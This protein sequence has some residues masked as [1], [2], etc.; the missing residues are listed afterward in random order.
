MAFISE[1]LAV[2]LIQVPLSAILVLNEIFKPFYQVDP[3]Q[4]NAQQPLYNTIVWVQD[5][6]HVGY[7]FCVIMRVKCINV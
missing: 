7:P 1:H 3:L 2:V 4:L 6:V 5:S